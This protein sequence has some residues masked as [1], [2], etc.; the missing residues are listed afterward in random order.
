MLYDG[1]LFYQNNMNVHFIFL[2]METFSQNCDTY[3]PRS[4]SE[5]KG[6][7]LIGIL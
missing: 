3:Y 6:K 1:L 2:P 7:N 4:I 5:E